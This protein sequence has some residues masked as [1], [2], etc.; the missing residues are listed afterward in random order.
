MYFILF[1]WHRVE[2]ILIYFTTIEEQIQPYFQSHFLNYRLTEFKGN[3]ELSLLIFSQI[4][5]I[6]PMQEANNKD[7]S[8]DWIQSPWFIQSR[9]LFNLIGGKKKISLEGT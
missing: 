2:I 7:P 8:T 4:A 9:W 5:Q 1:I 3:F 6:T